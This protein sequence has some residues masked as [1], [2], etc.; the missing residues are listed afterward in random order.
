M[1]TD[2]VSVA[3]ETSLAGGIEVDLVEAMCHATHSLKELGKLTRSKFGEEGKDLLRGAGAID[4]SAALAGGEVAVDGDRATVTP[5]DGRAIITLQKVQDGTWKVD[6]IKECQ[7][8]LAQ[9]GMTMDVL[10]LDLQSSS[11]LGSASNNF[12]SA[13]ARRISASS[14]CSAP[15]ASSRNRR[16]TRVSGTISFAPRQPGLGSKRLSKRPRLVMV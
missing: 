15:A 13:P 2:D 6:A 9:F 14:N 11:N 16:G 5:A 7:R 12:K 4:A 8:R 3:Q 10:T 1:E